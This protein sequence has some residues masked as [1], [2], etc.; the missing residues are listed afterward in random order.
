MYSNA[1]NHHLFFTT[2]ALCLYF[3]GRYFV[4]VGLKAISTTCLFGEV[5]VVNGAWSTVSKCVRSLSI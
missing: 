3:I 2:N 4:S 5:N 1:R